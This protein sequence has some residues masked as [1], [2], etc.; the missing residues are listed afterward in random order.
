M[1][2]IQQATNGQ[3][4]SG[5]FLGRI[6]TGAS[7]QNAVALSNLTPLWYRQ[8]FVPFVFQARKLPFFYAWRPYTYPLE[9]G[10]VWLTAMPTPTNDLNNG[11]MK[12]NLS[13][14]GIVS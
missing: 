4:E 3:S 13:L 6:V 5:S 11:M 8:Y 1:G 14:R 9:V 2:Y 10:F 12:V 7:N